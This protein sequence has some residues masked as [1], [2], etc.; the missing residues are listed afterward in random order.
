MPTFAGSM[1]VNEAR[2][3]LSPAW[4]GRAPAGRLMMIWESGLLTPISGETPF[5]NVMSVWPAVGFTLALPTYHGG[6]TQR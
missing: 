4:A 5:T 3:T 1:G 2:T 6:L